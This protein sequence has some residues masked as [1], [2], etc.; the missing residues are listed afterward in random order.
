MNSDFKHKRVPDPTKV[1][2]KQEKAIKGFLKEF[3][4][5]AVAKKTAHDKRKAE[6]KASHPTASATPSSAL[7]STPRVDEAKDEPGSDDDMGGV[8][9]DDDLAKPDISPEDAED[10]DAESSSDLKRKRVGSADLASLDGDDTTSP[11]KLRAA[12]PPPPPPPPPPPAEGMDES[13]MTP[14]E[15]GTE[16]YEALF[17]APGSAQEQ[18]DV[19]KGSQEDL[20]PSPSDGA[21]SRQSPT[22]LATPPTTN[23]GSC[24]H[25]SKV[26]ERL[27]E[28]EV[29]NPIRLKHLDRLGNF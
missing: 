9:D 20:R 2:P 16:P 29:G 14:V 12:T 7:D 18:L 28:V 8:S 10:D 26:R 3:F 11:K 15:E 27:Q 6:R 23:N 1:T 22:Q 13:D 17:L 24:E 5:K 25:D 21:S 19:A 4:D